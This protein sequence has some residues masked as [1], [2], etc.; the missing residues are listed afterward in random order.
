M[1]WG[2]QRHNEGSK[3]YTLLSEFLDVLQ[4]FDYVLVTRNLGLDGT[5]LEHTDCRSC[6]SPLL[7]LGLSNFRFWN[8][9]IAPCPV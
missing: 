9:N 1:L 4:C 7:D 3:T 6:R 5:R 8:L 2:L